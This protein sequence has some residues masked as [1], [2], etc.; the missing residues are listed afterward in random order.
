MITFTSETFLV[1]ICR[2]T[3]FLLTHTDHLP[4]PPDLWVSAK[5][6]ELNA[7]PSEDYKE[8]LTDSAQLLMDVHNGELGYVGGEKLFYL[9]L[10][11]YQ[12]ME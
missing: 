7:K 6:T 8:I 2:W 1:F 10:P 5:Y 3:D 11:N 12:K 9:H 4:R